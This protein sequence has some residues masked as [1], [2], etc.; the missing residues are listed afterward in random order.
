MMKKIFNREIRFKD[1]NL[2]YFGEWEEKI[3]G[4]LCKIIK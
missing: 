2:E 1:E 3:L 4:D